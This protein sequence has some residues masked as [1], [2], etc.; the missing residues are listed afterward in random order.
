MSDKKQRILLI[1]DEPTIVKMVSRR[2]E[3]SGF[4]VLVAKDGHEALTKARAENPDL[5]IIDLMLPGMNGFEVCQVL[6]KYPS[7][8]K[9]PIIIF[10][11]IAEK[12]GLDEKQCFDVGA[13][14]YIGKLEGGMTAL[15]DQIETLLSKKEN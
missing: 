9:I 2:L 10:S 12:M 15:L 5:I 8:Q 3:V 7:M 1:D 13:N 11:G 14:A 6:R 4:E